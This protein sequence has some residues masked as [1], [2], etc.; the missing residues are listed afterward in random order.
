MADYKACARC[1]DKTKDYRLCSGCFAD[2]C[3]DCFADGS[4]KTYLISVPPNFVRMICRE[5]VDYRVECS[6]YRINSLNEIVYLNYV[7][8]IQHIWLL[9]STW[10]A[11]AGAYIGV[12]RFRFFFGRCVKLDFDFF[13]LPASDRWRGR[14]RVV[15]AVL[16]SVGP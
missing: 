7:K 11:I 4:R 5:C 10:A 15:H 16:G 3:C 12:I 14:V 8:N 9:S 1:D 13:L 2:Y 6:N